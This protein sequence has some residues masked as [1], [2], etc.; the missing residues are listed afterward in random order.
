MDAMQ[1]PDGTYVGRTGLKC[2]FVCP[3]VA[4]APSS[5]EVNA[6]IGETAKGFLDVQITPLE[7]LEDSRCPLD[8]Q[9][10]Q[11]GTGGLK[12]KFVD[13]IG[14][15][16]TV[17]KLGVTVTGEAVAVTLTKVTPAPYSKVERKPEQY[18]FFFMLERMPG[19]R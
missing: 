15:S 18:Q 7:I 14:S 16:A 17:F 5:M 19:G 12:A 3:G 1:C 9:C 8:V 10:I 11:A 13:G 2:Q 4:S 6:K